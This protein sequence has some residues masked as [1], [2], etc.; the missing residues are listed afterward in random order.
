M[1]S[2][3]MAYY[4]GKP[5]DMMAG[6]YCKVMESSQLDKSQAI[7]LVWKLQKEFDL[8][9]YSRWLSSQY[10]LKKK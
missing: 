4:G 6:K 9:E 10:L 1:H 3:A 8:C 2:A 7:G 5:F